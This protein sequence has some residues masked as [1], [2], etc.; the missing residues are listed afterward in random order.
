MLVVQ[1]MLNMVSRHKVDTPIVV[2]KLCSQENREK[3][4]KIIPVQYLMEIMY[5]V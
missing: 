4:P 5:K 1:T 2:Q 3:T